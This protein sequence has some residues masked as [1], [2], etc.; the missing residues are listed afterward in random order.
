MERRNVTH[1]KGRKLDGY[2]TKFL[3]AK[4]EEMRLQNTIKVRAVENEKHIWE[5]NS[6]ILAKDAMNNIGKN[7]IIEPCPGCI[8][9]ENTDG[10]DCF[11]II[12]YK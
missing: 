5:K 7:A 2:C 4:K 3:Q 11:Q 9:C 8:N 6:L 12:V 10:R 1:L